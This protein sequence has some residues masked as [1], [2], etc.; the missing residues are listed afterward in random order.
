[1]DN[2]GNP[3]S[4]GKV[5]RPM[6]ANGRAIDPKTVGKYIKGL[7]ES[8]MVYRVNRYHIKGKQLL[9]TL[10]KYYTADIGIRQFLKERHI[11]RLL[12]H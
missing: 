9:A 5:A 2:I 4:S 6:A 7:T 10:E 11:I 3:F 8:L 12:R 1:M